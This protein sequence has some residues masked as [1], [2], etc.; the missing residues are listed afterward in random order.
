MEWNSTSGGITSDAAIRVVL[1]RMPSGDAVSVYFSVIFQN[2]N[3]MITNMLREFFASVTFN[4][5]LQE[6]SNPEFAISTK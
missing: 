3:Y 4:R 6:F 2:I 5:N 1:D